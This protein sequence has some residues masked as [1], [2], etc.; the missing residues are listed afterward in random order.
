MDHCIAEIGLTA[1]VIS[2]P[3]IDDGPHEM[4]RQDTL[5]CAA[6]ASHSGNTYFTL[7]SSS[8]LYSLSS[9]W[10]I[11]MTTRTNTV[12]HIIPSQREQHTKHQNQ[13]TSTKSV[14]VKDLHSTVTGAVRPEQLQEGD[15]RPC[16]ATLVRKQ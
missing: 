10:P 3:K 11:A 15:L 16:T 6:I 1:D 4:S 8:L 13:E 12:E 5:L 2:I 9:A 7:C 14:A